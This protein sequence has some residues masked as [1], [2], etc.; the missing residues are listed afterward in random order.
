MARA[1]ICDRC[2]RTMK[3]NDEYYTVEFAK[4]YINRSGVYCCHELDCELCSNC[5]KM[6]GAFME[7]KPFISNK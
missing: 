3:D 4:H 5:I 6:F 7:M 2:G 1:R